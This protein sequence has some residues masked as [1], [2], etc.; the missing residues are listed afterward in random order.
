MQGCACVHAGTR[1]EQKSPSSAGNGAPRGCSWHSPWKHARNS[2]WN[3]AQP[4]LP[5]PAVFARLGHT[6]K[7]SASEKNPQHLGR[8][9][10]GG[11][12][13][14]LRNPRL[15]QALT[16]EANRAGGGEGVGRDPRQPLCPLCQGDWTTRVSNVFSCSRAAPSPSQHPPPTFTCLRTNPNILKSPLSQRFSGWWSPSA[17]ARAAPCPQGG[18]S[19]LEKGDKEHL[20]LH[21]QCFQSLD[22]DLS[23]PLGRKR[24]AGMETPLLT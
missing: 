16:Q 9:G 24:E 13:S 23:L 8:G 3:G 14:E 19:L 2:Q 11:T 7:F 21:F 4:L 10:G 5:G 12:T 17:A 6:Q 15:S 18:N 20:E 22:M 1:Q